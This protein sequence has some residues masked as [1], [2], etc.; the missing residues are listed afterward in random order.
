MYI[1]EPGV[2]VELLGLRHWTPQM[3]QDSLRVH[4]PGTSLTSHACATVLRE[5]LGF[6]Q[7]F[8]ARSTDGDSA[9]TALIAVIEPQD[10][11]RVRVRP[12]AE[13][14]TADS[15][16]PWP[17]L[18]EA[19][20]AHGHLFQSALREHIYGQAVMLQARVPPSQRL[21]SA[22][23]RRIYELL[24]T[25]TTAEDAAIAR[26]LLESAPS[27][28]DRMA[29]AAVLS[30]FVNDD[31]TW[32]S[33]IGAQLDPWDGVRIF[34][35]TVLRSFAS[36]QPRDVDWRPAV[37]DLRAVLN[38][39]A[40]FTLPDVLTV[41]ARTG[42]QPEL[43]EPLLKGG[44]YGVAMYVATTLP[45]TRGPAYRFLRAVNSKDGATAA[46][47]RKWIADL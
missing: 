43:A 36:E 38:G 19:V 2:T 3:L 13:D 8:S 32:Y 37:D 7:V 18:V 5:K 21:D 15:Q 11:A 42:V 31:A 14:T 28:Y 12:L 16:A 20:R 17:E 34:A 9:L 6:P 1:R 23:L 46:E 35:G 40:L 10:S 27:P 44:G 24:D 47:W 45:Y 39:S 33:L 41:L 30:N 26:R 22:N 4:A 29:A 25:F